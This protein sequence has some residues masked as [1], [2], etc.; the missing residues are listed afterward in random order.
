MEVLRSE[1]QHILGKSLR[2]TTTS[3]HDRMHISFLVFLQESR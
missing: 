1:M 2:N 3:L